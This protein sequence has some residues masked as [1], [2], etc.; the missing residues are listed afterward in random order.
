MKKFILKLAAFAFLL[1][2]PFGT[3]FAV[4]QTLPNIYTGSFMGVTSQKLDLLSKTEGEKIV[5]AGGSNLIYGISCEQITQQLNVPTFNM[6]T[7]AY[8]GLPFFISEIKPHL[9]SGDT[10]VLSLEYSVLSG[11][12]DYN[13]VLMALESHANVW[14]NVPYDYL[15]SIARTYG[16]FVNDKKAEIKETHTKD[17]GKYTNLKTKQE[18]YYEA[19]FNDYG[20]RHNTYDTNIL[21][22]LYNT[23]DTWTLSAHTVTDDVLNELNAF[24]K[25]ADK[26][27]VDVYM[28]Y[29]TFNSL[30]LRGGEDDETGMSG[31]IELEEYLKL[32]CDIPWLGSFTD[33]IMGEEYFSDTN[34]HLNS[35]GKDIRTQ[36]F[37][38]NY[39]LFING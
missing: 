8:L 5:I 13:T 34:N 1:A 12:T 39:K 6:G 15:V 3:F 16:D 19:G 11:Q 10:V 14:Q 23:Q 18:A 29:A 32:N 24:K 25:W 36:D 37:I 17:G 9:K 4:H 20:D 26:N 2:L 30:A 7:T 35:V 21:E 31:A 28:T 27:D 38:E 33:G 22:N